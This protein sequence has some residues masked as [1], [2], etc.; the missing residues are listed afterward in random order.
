MPD[1]LPLAD[2]RNA[3]QKPRPL[4]RSRRARL[5]KAQQSLPI[6]REY[7]DAL[8][9]AHGEQH[10]WPAQTPFE[11]VL[12]AILVQNTSWVNVEQAIA[13]LRRAGLL[14]PTALEK[15]PRAKLARLIR[16]SGYFRQKA[17]KVHEFLR[18]LRR[19]YNGSLGAMLST[20]T[21]GLR[22]QLL[23]IHG[24]GPETADSILL[25]AGN[26]PVFVVDAYTRRILERH[27]LTQGK[28]SYEDL[29]GLFERSLPDDASLF[30]E[31][32]ALIVHTGKHHC[33]SRVALCSN[34]ALRPFL[35]QSRE[36]SA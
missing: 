2:S 5:P 21:V 32:H 12:G 22:E 3:A 17:R 30:N 1:S 23:S 16:P 28:E 4:A 31:Y 26:H 24:I 29:R 14:S 7:Y 18:F 25:Y 20:P 36:P 19:E 27:G 11:V 35:P 34:C 6:L 13:N 9:Q 33:R 8:L 15:T 10:W